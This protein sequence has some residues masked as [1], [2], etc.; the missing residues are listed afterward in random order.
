MSGTLPSGTFS[1]GPLARFGRRSRRTVAL[2]LP[3]AVGALLLASTPSEATSSPAQIATSKTNGVNYLKS[4]QAADGSYVTP[5]GLS[6]EWAFS[7]LAAAG[8]AA[9]DVT[10]GGDVTKNAR[11]VYRNQLSAP[12]W[13]SASPVATDYQRA[14]LNAN[15]AGIDPARVAVGRNLIADVVS[16]WQ[17]AAPGYYGPPANFNGTVFGLLALGG[18]KTQAGVQ[19]VPQSLLNASIAVVRAN[20]HNDGGWNFSQAAGNP[21]QLAATSDIDM[22]GA[23]IASLCVSGVANTDAAVVAGKNFLKS[24]LVNTTG[25]FNAM[26]G[27]NTDSNGWAVSGLNACGFNAQGADFT[28]AAGKT[29]IDFLLANQFNPGGGF[30]YQPSDTSPTA[31][32]SIDALRGVA[33]AGFTAVPPTPVTVGAPKWVGTSAFTSGTASKLALIVDTGAGAL[34][35]CSVTITPTG[36]TSNLGAVL[37]AALASSTPSGCVTSRTPTS[38]TGTVTEVNGVTNAG[39]NT[40]KVSID[41]ATAAGATRGTVVNVG[42]TISLRYGV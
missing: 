7:A 37:D 25:A 27:V 42:D 29:P 30:K 22:T 2:G 4:L 5:G 9:V 18:S 20:E 19:R 10:P 23:A 24:K 6:N 14:T 8:T 35:V 32:S 16:Y 38:G 26:F 17:T 40:W 3:L 12:S 15:A 39:A 36:T 34:K 13:P 11:T 1:S 31:Y 41:G 28:T 21:T 33:G